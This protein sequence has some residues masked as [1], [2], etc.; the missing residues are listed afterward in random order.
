M[1]FAAVAYLFA[2]REKASMVE[3]VEGLQQS[4]IVQRLEALVVALAED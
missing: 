1:S 2:P 4:L 3:L